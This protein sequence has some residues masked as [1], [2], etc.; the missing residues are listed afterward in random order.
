[1]ALEGLSLAQTPPIDADTEAPGG[2]RHVAVNGGVD[3]GAKTP[4]LP[5]WTR[6]EIL[7]LIQGKRVV[8]SRV[9]RGRTAGLEF[10]SAQVE[11]KWAAV[12]SYCLRHGVNR[13]PVQCRKRWSNL[14]GDFKKIRE[15]EAQTKDETES[16]WVMRNDLRRER[17]LPGFFDREVYDILDGGDCEELTARLALALGPSVEAGAEDPE[18]ETLFDSGRSAAAED[19][20][21]S[22]FEPSGQEETGFASPGKELLPEKDPKPIAIPAP[23]PISEQQYEPFSQHTPAKGAIHQKQPTTTEPGI[24]SG[25]EGRKRKRNV[26]DAG[27]EEEEESENLQQQLLKALERNGKLLSSQLEAQNEHMQLDR[28][29]R[30]D[31][32]NSLISVLNKL[33]DALGKIADKL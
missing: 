14:A 18:A 9:R 20:L 17:K 22:D 11:P 19:G 3:D 6:Q 12:S 23:I 13:G 32:V 27:E 2:G 16:F 21:F 7:V 10:G 30:K 15:W 33:S 5:R 25:P 26:T 29:Q 28:E 31:H 4:R 24:G 8:E 1:M